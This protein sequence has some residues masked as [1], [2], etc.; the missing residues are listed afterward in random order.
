MADENNFVAVVVAIEDET[1]IRSL[2]ARLHDAWARGDGAAYAQCFA[3][4]SDYITFNGMHLRSR[5]ENSA[6]HSALFRG[7]LKD[8]GLSVEIES[9]VLLSSNI[10]LVHTAGSE[11]KRSYQTYVLVKSGGDWLIR[12]FRNTRVQPLSV[13]ITRWAQRCADRR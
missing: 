4:Q 13:K 8:T 2:L 6:V 11:R 10:A 1:A 5:A 12:S 3:E 9:I 7:V